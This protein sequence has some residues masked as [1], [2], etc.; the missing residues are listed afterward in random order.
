MVCKNAQRFFRLPTLHEQPL[1]K[2][3]RQQSV[4]VHCSDAG[5]I[6]LARLVIASDRNSSALRRCTA[7]H[8]LRR[9]VGDG[10]RRVGD[11]HYE[12]TSNHGIA[13]AGMLI[14]REAGGWTNAVPGPLMLAH[15]GPSLASAPAGGDAGVALNYRRICI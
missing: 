8:H 12:R 7:M 6:R 13:L 2:K 4:Q 5:S 3:A 1:A 10:G 9:R 15:G 11:A 14:F